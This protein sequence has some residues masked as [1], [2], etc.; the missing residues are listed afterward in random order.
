MNISWGWKITVLYSSF[1]VLMIG[2]VIASM[3]QNF[4]L[5]SDEYYKDEIAYQKV[6]DAS[7][8]EAQLEGTLAIHADKSTLVIDFPV[9]MKG[10]VLK[11]EVKFYSPVNAGWDKTFSINAP[12]NTMSIPLLDLQPT[13][14][15]IKIS[16]MAD[17]KEYY[18][19][20]EVNLHRI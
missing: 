3:R 13:S 18:R 10:K 17:G 7:K 19:E 1:A 2:L 14:Y 20:S 9:D 12:D 15:K 16:Y 11:G 4:D 6:I 5:V 8:N